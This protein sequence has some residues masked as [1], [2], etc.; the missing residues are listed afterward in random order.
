MR[1]MSFPTP[2]PTRSKRWVGVAIGAAVLVVTAAV[3]TGLTMRAD[4]TPN[5]AAASASTTLATTTPAAQPASTVVIA[6]PAALDACD[7]ANKLY[8]APGSD[9]GLYNPAKT[10]PVGQRAAQSFNAEVK[11]WGAE[12][13]D[14]AD[15]ADAAVGRDAKFQT[16]LQAGGAVTRFLTYCTEQRFVIP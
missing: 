7:M 1:A 11:R 13:I 3:I 15:A 5:S 4:K 16:A 8:K 14:K 2:A 12:I 6:D 9:T 10:R